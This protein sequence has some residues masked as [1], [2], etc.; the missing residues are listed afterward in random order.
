MSFNVGLNIVEVDGTATP[1]IQ[2]AATSITGFIIKSARGIPGKVRRVTNWSQFKEHFGDYISTGYGA[3][4]VRGFFDNGGQTAI[5]TRVMN[6]GDAAASPAVIAT[7]N[8]PWNL[9]DA[10]KVSFSIDGGSALEAIFSHLPASVSSI[11][12]PFNLSNDNTLGF[13]V[14]G[15]TAD[16]YVFVSDDAASG[17]LA[18]ITAAEVAAAIN[19]K[20][21]GISASVSKKIVTVKTDRGDSDAT[22][23]V[24]G[25]AATSLGFGAV[26]SASGNVASIDNVTPA[27]VVAIF[28]TSLATADV[29]VAQSGDSVT[30]T[31]NSA[32]S[33]NTIQIQAWGCRGQ[34]RF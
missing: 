9:A 34:L 33:S 5:V 16:D 27:E 1:S 3:Y 11:A 8:G 17:D 22:L 29:T 14:N 21:A 6:A 4:S 2:P 10:N 23:A 31:N 18:T 32:G 15:V 13:K 19:R 28:N 7:N 20:F 24:I 25:S 12:G 30:I 26:T